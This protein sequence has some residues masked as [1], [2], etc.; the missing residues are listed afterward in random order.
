MIICIGN[1]LVDSLQQ[2]EEEVIDNLNL[3]KA[4]MTLVDKERSNFLLKNMPNPTYAAGGSAANTAYWIAALG[5]SVGFIGKIS[6]D[7]LGNQFKSS[8]SEHG[9]NDFTVFEEGDEQTGLCAIFITPDG[10]RTMNTYLGAGA[11]LSMGDLDEESIKN[12]NI[13]YMEGYL[14]DRLPSKEA[15]LYASSINKQSGGKNALSLS[16]VFCVE[17]HR[18]SFVDLIKE[19]IDF[20]FCNEDEIKALTEQDSIEKSLDFINKNF[21]KLDQLICTLGPKG[22][23]VMKD[24]KQYFFDATEA[25]VVDKTGAGDYFAAGYLF[26]IEK[27]LS[28]EEAALIANKS[29]AHV[30]S[31]IGVRPKNDFS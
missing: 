10:E 23:I 20:V 14:W 22:A 26:G 30:I 28:M 1:A 21:P 2:I 29:A 19:N 3:N 16:D 7:D 12:C 9:L 24:S 4:R 31:E 27:K 8:L 25:D 17:A 5:G 18:D 15:F 6:D 11:Q 13:L